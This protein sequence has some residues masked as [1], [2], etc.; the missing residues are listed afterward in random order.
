MAKV[1]HLTTVHKRYDTRI[2]L[3][4]CRSLTK[5]GHSVALIVADGLGDEIRDGV[6]IYDIGSS[7]GRLDR[8]LRASKKMY[9][10]GLSLDAEIYHLHDPELIPVGL[11]L[12]KN[13][14]KVIFDSHE[15]VPKQLTGKPYLNSVY[16]WLLP[17]LFAKYEM[18]ASRKLDCVVAATPYIRDKFSSLDVISVDV[19]NFP[20]VDELFLTSDSHNVKEKQVCYVGALSE[21]RGIHEIVKAIDLVSSDTTLVI[22]GEFPDF[23]FESTV[24][25]HAG[26]KKVVER[27]WLDRDAVR[28]VLNESVAG[29]VTLHPTINYLD[30]LPVKMF[31]YMAAGLPVVCSNFPLWKSIVEENRCGVCVDPLDPSEIARAIEY[32]INHPEEASVMG[33]NGKQAVLKKYNWAEEEKKL[34]D[35]YD[36]IRS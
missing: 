23:V 5:R 34:F 15:D 3:K 21:I 30:A 32:L 28:R 31:E 29:L 24:K 27:G 10:K 17:K 25:N 4:E 20:I 1:V 36:Q 16:R 6:S 18:W 13:G 11:K 12:K 8:I 22:G 14:K 7:T 19:N 9:R 2:F 26:W 33:N 35:I